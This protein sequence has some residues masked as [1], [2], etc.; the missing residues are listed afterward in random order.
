MILVAAGLG[1]HVDLGG[2]APELGRVNA[3][4]HLELLQRV[5]RGQDHVGVEVGVGI[6]DAVQREVV[7]HDALSGHR[8][9]LVGAVAALARAGL[10]GGRRDGGDVGRE[11]DQLQIVAAVERQFDDALV[12]DHGTDGGVLGLQLGGRTRYLD[13]FGYLS[14][15]KG[16]IQAN[17]LLH[18]HL[19]LV[20]G[21]AS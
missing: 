14:E 13:G 12:L 4:L 3:G 5:D 15:R 11:R 7:E 19:D 2:V 20:G 18:L 6:L 17:G 10:A 21:G 1:E 16:D 9:R 8:D